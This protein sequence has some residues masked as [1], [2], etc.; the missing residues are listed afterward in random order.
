M[1][2]FVVPAFM[3]T[4]VVVVVPRRARTGFTVAWTVV[5]SL[6]ELDAAKELTGNAAIPTAAV[7]LS[8]AMIFVDIVFVIVETFLN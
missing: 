4:S 8:A 7:T 5:V 2:L 3:F 6:E 1:E